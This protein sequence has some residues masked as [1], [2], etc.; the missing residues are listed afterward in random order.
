M[1]LE[2]G[3]LVIERLRRFNDVYS[4]LFVVITILL[5]V[6]ADTFE[7]VNLGSTVAFILGSLIAWIVGHLIGAQTSLRHIEIQFKLIA[8]L[9]A[10]LVA[11][12]VVLKYALEIPNLT[13]LVSSYC[14]AASVGSGLAM[15][16]YL[17]SG[18]HLRDKDESIMLFVLLAVALVLYAT[19]AGI[20]VF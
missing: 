14:I 1:Q 20:V 4:L 19:Y 2:K 15:F 3:G 7:K 9:Y 6:G 18:I 16:F 12:D 10:S 17:Q 5:T 8:W 11:G 13:G